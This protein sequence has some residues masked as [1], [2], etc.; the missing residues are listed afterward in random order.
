MGRG[1]GDGAIKEDD[2]A[3]NEYADVSRSS[4]NAA[5]E[6]EKGM[7]LWG[8]GEKQEVEAQHDTFFEFHG[9]ERLV[10]HLQHSLALLEEERRDKERDKDELLASFSVLDSVLNEYRVEEVGNKG[11]EAL[12]ESIKHSPISLLPANLMHVEK[13]R[14]KNVSSLMVQ[15]DFKE[16]EEEEITELLVAGMFEEKES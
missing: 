13:E 16:E 9:L 6:L 8:D 11:G 12:D 2:C 14:K 10:L 3:I 15:G 5:S 1:A 7:E 4:V